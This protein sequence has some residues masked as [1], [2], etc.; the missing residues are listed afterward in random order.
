MDVETRTGK[1][2]KYLREI[3]T[4]AAPQGVGERGKKIY[5]K[6]RSSM[7]ETR[8]LADLATNA[9]TTR[10]PQGGG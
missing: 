1:G 4:Y 2:N 9:P 8:R 7:L 10:V 5:Q 3:R 6:A